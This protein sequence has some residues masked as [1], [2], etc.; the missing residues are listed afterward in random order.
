MKKRIFL[1]TALTLAGLGCSGIGFYSAAARQA[2]PQPVELTAEPSHHLLFQN[3][4]ARV[5]NVEV[6]PHT[7]TL[8]H[9]HAYD[10]IYVTLG[11]TDLINEVVG[12]APARLKLKDGEVRFAAGGFAHR[13]M[14]LAPTPFR[15]ITVEILKPNKE[16][17]PAD[18]ERGLDVGHGAMVETLFVQDGVVAKDVTINPRQALAIASGG[19]QVLVALSRA[20][21]RDEGTDHASSEY[22]AERGDARWVAPRMNHRWRNVGAKP[23]RFI[24][25]EFF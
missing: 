5:F 14:N 25:L 11:D 17:K 23:A 4:Y 15:N 3:E 21:L 1:A 22:H 16:A 6:A 13:A 8:V 9:R 10:Y 19:P 2:S 24:M 12:K 20:E 18:E 7:A